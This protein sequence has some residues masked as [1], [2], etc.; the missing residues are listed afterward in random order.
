M[1]VQN[2]FFTLQSLA[3]FAGAVGATT[4]VANGCQ[5]AFNFNPSWFALALAEVICVAV[6]FISHTDAGNA[7]TPPASDYFVAVI[8]GFLV[9]C[10][11]SGATR[12]LDNTVGAGPTP[13]ASATERGDSTRDMVD[14]RPRRRFLSPWF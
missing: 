2:D 3:T 6:V 12:A 5:R 8:N 14:S 7:I 10:S 13:T 11:A 1:A 4:V 9:Y